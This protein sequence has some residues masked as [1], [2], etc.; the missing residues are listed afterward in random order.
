MYDN[1]MFG[2]MLMQLEGKPAPGTNYQPPHLE[3]VADVNR[4]FAADM[5]LKYSLRPVPGPTLG[6]FACYGELI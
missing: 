4:P 5:G 1:P 6:I 2:A 3:P